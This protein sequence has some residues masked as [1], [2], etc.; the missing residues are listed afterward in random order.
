MRAGFARSDITPDYPMPMAGY[1]R[2][3]SPSSGVLDP[4]FVSVI[5]IEDD[6]QNRAFIASFDLLGT[7]TGLCS[8][9]KDKANALFRIDEN[10][11]LISATHTHS[12]PAPIFFR[13]TL[14]E[15]YMEKLTSS[16]MLAIEQAME[17]F[18]FAKVKLIGAEVEGVASLRAMARDAAAFSMQSELLEFERDKGSILLCN[19]QCHPTVLN[20]ENTL[21]SRDLPGACA[22]HL[23]NGERT[24]FLNSACADISTRYARRASTPEELMRLGGIWARALNAA[25]ER[26]QSG[27]EMKISVASGGAKVFMPPAKAFVGLEKQALIQSLKSRIENTADIALKHEFTSRLIVLERPKYGTAQGRDIHVT[28][29]DLGALLIIGLPLETSY[30][31][32][33]RFKQRLS[34]MTGKPVWIICYTGGYDGYL[35]SGRP[36]D[37]DSSYEDL[38]AI[39]SSDA[40]D[41]V[42]RCIEECALRNLK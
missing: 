5:A 32:G 17:D 6:T 26:G 16:C 27:K 30:E 23:P 42:W 35:P 36:L 28:Y 33:E 12:A 39:Y 29:M 11:I 7:D 41:I 37:F 13:N 9:I 25:L 22:L 10:N 20:E 18:S 40:E 8:R 3:K 4:L 15:K 24:A 31:A 19:F 38:A 34:E 21:I 14:D 1:D 2:R